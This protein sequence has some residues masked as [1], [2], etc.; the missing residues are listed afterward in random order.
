M[1]KIITVYDSSQQC[2]ATKM[3]Q[4]LDVEMDCPYTGK[5]EKF[6]PGELLE[7]ALAGCMLIFCG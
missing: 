4:N 1:S 2:K 5:G 6:S 3:H 7:S